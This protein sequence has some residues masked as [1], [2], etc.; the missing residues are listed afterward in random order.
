MKERAVMFAG[1]AL[2]V[3]IY[4]GC[5]TIAAHYFVERILR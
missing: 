3:F 4:V 2:S 1:F 5:L